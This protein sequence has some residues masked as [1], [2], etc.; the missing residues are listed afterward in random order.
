MAPADR[1]IEHV[2]ADMLEETRRPPDGR[3][4]LAVVERLE[5]LLPAAAPI[6]QAGDP[7]DERVRFGHASALRF[8]PGEVGDL[9]LRG[10]PPIA[11]VTASFFG[12]CGAG[13]PLPLY[14]AEEADLDEEPGSIVRGLLDVFHH[15]LF[16]LLVRG[17]REVD[18]PR[19]MRRVGSDL[20]AR[21][22]LALLGQDLDAASVPPQTLLQLA[23]VL[24]SGVRSPEMLAVALR[25]CLA[26]ELGGAALRVEALSG[27]WMPI[28]P[29][30][31]SR[32]GDATTGLGD[33]AVLGTEALHPAGAAQVVIG[34]VGGEQ[35]AVFLPGGAAHDRLRALTRG[36]TPEPLHY[37]LVLEIEDMTYPPGLL[38]LRRLGQDLWLARSDHRGVRTRVVVPVERAPAAPSAQ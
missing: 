12:L 6:G 22:V 31:W 15:R 4:L 18:L 38:G 16:S 28:D 34:P 1:R 2:S 30:Q 36:F 5:R 35:H 33:T 7:R 17:L 29:S 8:D 11:L 14:L 20:W 27:A 23:P 10:E 24:A 25:I 19:S 13:T 9:E 26:A 32:L 37:D 3:D 21:R